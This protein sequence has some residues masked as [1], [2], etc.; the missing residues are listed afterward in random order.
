MA[1]QATFVGMQMS[2][3][4]APP[5]SVDTN[6]PPSYSA[7][8]R[9]DALPSYS[10][11]LAAVAPPSYTAVTP[12]VPRGGD[13][14]QHA[15]PSAEALAERALFR[16]LSAAE[17][18]STAR[19]PRRLGEQ[20]LIAGEVQKKGSGLLKSWSRRYAAV[21]E[22]SKTLIYFNNQAEFTMSPPTSVGRSRRELA[23]VT[24]ASPGPPTSLS[25]WSRTSLFSSGSHPSPNATAGS[26][27]F[28]RCLR[29]GPAC[30]S[31]IGGARVDVAIV[32]SDSTRVFVHDCAA[33]RAAR[34]GRYRTH[35]P[36]DTHMRVRVSTS[37]I[38]SQ[39]RVSSHRCES[40][41]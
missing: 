34:G 14:S 27:C 10:E 8:N 32:Y 23:A 13:A 29:L 37:W 25:S 35:C 39:H 38:R 1:T 6:A 26:T 11:V 19:S 41:E 4:R 7:F 40:E 12:Q 33:R 18:S 30:R 22:S 21:F 5:S 16:A 9:S 20:P 31:G 3:A 24:P 17:S 36:I 15:G 2:T 28:P